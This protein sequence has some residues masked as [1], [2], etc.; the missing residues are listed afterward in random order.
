MFAGKEIIKPFLLA[1]GALGEI[2]GAPISRWEPR[3]L[4]Q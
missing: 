1:L 4:R 3:V 2:V